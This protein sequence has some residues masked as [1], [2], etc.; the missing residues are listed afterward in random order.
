VI[1][2]STNYCT[3]QLSRLL[4]REA[5]LSVTERIMRAQMPRARKP[6]GAG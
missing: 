5:V 3:A 6:E 4:P 2:S 1:D